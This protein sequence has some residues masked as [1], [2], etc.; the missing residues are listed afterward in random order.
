MTCSIIV[1]CSVLP[2]DATRAV[3]LSAAKFHP[4]VGRFEHEV[5]EWFGEAGNPYETCKGIFHYLGSGSDKPRPYENPYPRDVLVFS[6]GMHD[7]RPGHK[8]DFLGLEAFV[9]NRLG[10]LF[11]SDA[12]N[13]CVLLYFAR[14]RGI[15]TRLVCSAHRSWRVCHHPLTTTR[16][17]RI[18]QV[19]RSVVERRE[20]DYTD[21]LHSG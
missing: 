8:S 7:D 16:R 5:I 2:L 6:S 14:A 11:T 10:N 4:R 20:A 19:D 1:A 12:E 15:R 9:A 3:D 17:A 21:A 13:S 18:I